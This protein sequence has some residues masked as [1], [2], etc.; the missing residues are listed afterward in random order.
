MISLVNVRNVINCVCE[1]CGKEFIASI[2]HNTDYFRI[3]GACYHETIKTN[4][5][6]EKIDERHEELSGFGC[7]GSM[8]R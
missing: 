4:N 6:K 5:L 3:C 7:D 1:K 2:Y 8:A